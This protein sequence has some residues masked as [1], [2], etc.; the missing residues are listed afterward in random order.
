M[1]SYVILP[2]TTLQQKM[3]VLPEDLVYQ[4]VQMLHVSPK[5][6]KQKVSIL[7]QLVAFFH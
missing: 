5:N 2:I 1:K 3:R 4:R 6:T 7:H